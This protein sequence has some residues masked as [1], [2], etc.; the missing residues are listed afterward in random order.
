MKNDRLLLGSGGVHNPDG[1]QNLVEVQRRNEELRRIL[2]ELAFLPRDQAIIVE[3]GSGPLGERKEMKVRELKREIMQVLP[4]RNFLGYSPRV[5]SWDPGEYRSQVRAENEHRK[6]QVQETKARIIEKLKSLDPNSPVVTLEAMFGYYEI[7]NVATLID[8]WEKDSTR[9]DLE[10]TLILGAPD[11][12]RQLS[13]S[14][15]EEFIAEVREK[16]VGTRQRYIEMLSGHGDEEFVWFRTKKHLP[17][18]NKSTVAELR[19]ILLDMGKYLIG[20]TLGQENYS[21]IAS[22]LDYF[23]YT[24]RSGGFQISFSMPDDSDEGQKARKALR[25]KQREEMKKESEE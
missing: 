8:L 21:L 23:D 18:W 6:D 3:F 5:V 17:P 11:P 15:T 9:L 4:N 22:D 25:S 7:R 12:N 20:A 2:N 10:D 16:F 19:A 13:Q 1:D 14:T 24:E